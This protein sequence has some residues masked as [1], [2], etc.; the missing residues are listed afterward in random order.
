MFY[1]EAQIAG[2]W[3][4]EDNEKD[5]TEVDKKARKALTPNDL[6]P[7]FKIGGEDLP[8]Y[9]TNLDIMVV[10]IEGS[11]CDMRKSICKQNYEDDY[12]QGICPHRTYAVK[13]FNE[14]Y[15]SGGDWYSSVLMAED[16]KEKRQLLHTYAYRNLA[17]ESLE[18]S[19]SHSI[20]WDV[21]LI[22]RTYGTPNFR[23]SITIPTDIITLEQL[24]NAGAY[25][26]LQ[27]ELP[28][29]REYKDFSKLDWDSLYNIVRQIHLK[30]SYV[31]YK[32]LRRDNLTTVAKVILAQ[33]IAQAVLSDDEN[34]IVK[35]YYELINSAIPVEILEQFV[36][37]ANS[38]DPS[39]LIPLEDS[40]KGTI[41]YVGL[42][43]YCTAYSPLGMEA[44]KI[45]YKHKV[46]DLLY[47]LSCGSDAV[48]TLELG[49]RKYKKI[50]TPR[51]K[52][53]AQILANGMDYVKS[54]ARKTSLTTGMRNYDHMRK[55]MDETTARKVAEKNKAK[56]DAIAEFDFRM[57]KA[58]HSNSQPYV[59]PGDGGLPSRAGKSATG[60][61]YKWGDLAVI[62]EPLTKNLKHKI[63]GATHKPNEYGVIPHYTDRFFSDKRMFRVKKNIKGGTVLIDA[64]G[65]MSLSEDD[66]FEIIQAL[67]ASV[68]AMYSGTAQKG[69]ARGGGDGELCILAKNQRMVSSLPESLVENIVDYP[70]LVWLSKMPK[71]RIWVSDEEVTMLAVR[72]GRYEHVS[73]TGSEQ[74][75]DLVKKAGIITLA[76]IEAVVDF[77]KSIKRH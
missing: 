61:R 73:R 55:Y 13:L 68:V 16:M 7:I 67:P 25:Y 39:C 9:E 60:A 36:R 18:Y 11:K 32:K 62:Q 77:A 1:P 63:K 17:K 51:Y 12:V 5:T 41:N 57:F 52:K 69:R 28:R 26:D 59:I 45:D 43:E 76:N 56:S 38:H 23:V 74:C 34:A 48:H 15:I 35:L 3:D 21:N 24:R 71:P 40:L 50:T 54:K 49:M 46:N 22:N 31:W 30:R 29:I 2:S 14:H 58:K 42:N 70:A 72:G 19:E 47:L 33:K 65:S 20:S 6:T 64:S 4:I 44:S 8:V 27:K 75:T 53:A 66:I 10:P 37:G